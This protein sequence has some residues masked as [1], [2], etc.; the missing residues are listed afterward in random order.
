MIYFSKV[1]LQW[2]H[3]VCSN[4]LFGIC[5][6]LLQK[7]KVYNRAHN[8]KISYGQKRRALV[9]YLCHI[10]LVFV[11]CELC[12]YVSVSRSH[13]VRTFVANLITIVLLYLFLMTS[14]H[15]IRYTIPLQHYDNISHE[16]LSQSHRLQ[17]YSSHSY[18]I[19]GEITSICR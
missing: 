5:A 14:V 6:S 2:N 16:Y 1:E 11:S 3:I 9:A 19:T 7:H 17:R 15:N 8:T 18:I 4:F 13:F 12:H 10:L